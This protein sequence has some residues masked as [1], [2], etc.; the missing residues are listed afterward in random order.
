MF[1][2]SAATI[3]NT[4]RLP[5]EFVSRAGRSIVLIGLL[6][7]AIPTGLVALMQGVGSLKLPFNLFVVDQRLP[8]TF[9][10]HMLAAGLS[11]LLIPLAIWL[12]RRNLSAHRLAGRAAAA[13][14]VTGALTSVPVALL[15]ESH[16]MARAGFLFQGAAWLAL[17]IAGVQAV[18]QRRI[19]D[20]KRF[21]LAMAGVATG[22]IWVRMT[23]TIATVWGLPF[24]PLY[25]CAA[26]AGWIVPMWVAWRLAP[27]LVLT[28]G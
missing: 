22:A 19:A 17:L 21:M 2:D 20:H 1:K 12:P 4:P 11:L 25:A 9:R 23:T 3:S 27:R 14:V 15:S 26:W 28:A 8:V 5:G 16:V 7:L 24:D 18:R 13:C 10:L 6:A